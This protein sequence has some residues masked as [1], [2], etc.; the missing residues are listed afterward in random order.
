VDANA[1][2]SAYLSHALEDLR[3]AV[4]DFRREAAVD[5]G[6]SLM[7]R[8]M[9]PLDREPMAGFL[10]SVL[11]SSDFDAWWLAAN[12]GHLFTSGSRSIEWPAELS[13]RVGLQLDLCRKIS[14]GA[15]SIHEVV[16]KAYRVG[17]SKSYIVMVQSMASKLIEPMARDIETLARRR[18]LPTASAQAL[19]ARPQSP[20]AELDQMLEEACVLFASP[21]PSERQRALERLWDAWERAK[22]LHG[23]MKQSV[24]KLLDDATTEPKFRELIEE[25]A[26][27]LT[28]AGNAFYIRHKGTAQTKLPRPEETD[29]L[30]MRLHTLLV[31]VLGGTR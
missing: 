12:D 7:A 8:V 14:T 6:Q 5:N 28:K 20:D 17:G 3:S 21:V 2:A 22:T 18:V 30:F 1:P 11:P 10:R 29:Y 26:D 23:D 13:E 15:Q 24:K 31:L 27:A 4:A 19:R 16:F 9:A 25:D